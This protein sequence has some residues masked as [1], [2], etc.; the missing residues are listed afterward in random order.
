M[1]ITHHFVT[2]TDGGE[3]T[4]ERREATENAARTALAALALAAVCYYRTAG[5]DLRS[6]SLLVPKGPQVFELLSRDG[7]TPE[8]RSLTVAD[9]AK[10]LKEAAA[11]AAKHGLA[12]VRGPVLLK[13]APKLLQLIRESRKLKQVGEAEE[14]T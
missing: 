6:R 14:L 4:P 10:L 5:F 7:G 11:E 8:E 9:A 13:P 3:I 12:W 2:R 1:A